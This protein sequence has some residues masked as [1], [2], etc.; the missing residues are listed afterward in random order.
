MSE[1]LTRYR[2]IFPDWSERTIARYALSMRRLDL[3][4]KS[5]DEKAAVINEL[6]ERLGVCLEGE[7]GETRLGSSTPSKSN[8]CHR[9]LQCAVLP[10]KSRNRSLRQ[11]RQLISSTRPTPNLSGSGSPFMDFWRSLPLPRS[12]SVKRSSAPSS[13]ARKDSRHPK[14]DKIDG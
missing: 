8:S 7:H 12:A 9:I 14:H 4:G 1:A 13:P 5:G 10:H 11:L 3:I 6:K 2:L